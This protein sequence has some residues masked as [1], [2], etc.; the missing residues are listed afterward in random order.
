MEKNIEY[1]DNTNK[2]LEL[3]KSAKT[4]GLEAIGLAAEGNAKRWL[5]Y[6]EAVDTGRLRNSITYALA[7]KEAHIKTYKAKKGG[8]GRE[9]YHYDGVAEGEKG[10]AVYIGTNV[11][12][13]PYVELGTVNMDPRPF[14]R[15]AAEEHAE[16]YERLMRKSLENA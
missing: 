13:A 15:P 14:L 1:R 16:Q 9:T 6:Q 12:Y 3:F 10:S 8:K 11:E 7:G 5:T 4:R 2:I